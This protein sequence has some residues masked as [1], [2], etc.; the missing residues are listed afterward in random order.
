MS[1]SDAQGRVDV[2]S[3][4]EARSI[5]GIPTIE[6]G[7]DL[8]SIIEAALS[9]AS[10]VLEDHDILVLA[11]KV[12]SRA[13]NCFVDLSR[14]IPSD[15]A[16]AV[17]ADVDKDPRLVEVI[18]SES[19]G[20]SRKREGAL[21]VRHRLGFVSANAGIDASNAA[22]S[23]A[24]HDS[25]PWVL[26]LPRNPDETARRLRAHLERA[27]GT[28]L[29]VVLTDSWGRP[30]RRGTVGFALGSSGL[31]PIADRRG[32]LDRHGRTLE[33]TETATADAVAAAA[34]LIA[35]QAD[36]GRPLTL[37]RGLRFRPSDESS[38]ALL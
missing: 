17:A 38:D 2:A 19:D 20:V 16:I 5:L 6:P 26:T 28:Q 29:G 9:R 7:D 22:P 21:I 23:T 18:L 11:S 12:V 24:A 1:E 37:I 10:V 14:V 31:P 35:G 8:A 32:S 4:I 36:E 25:G 13:Q 34:D 33:A 15:E 27:S 3:K 30:F